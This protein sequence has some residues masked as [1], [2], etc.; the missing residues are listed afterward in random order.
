MKLTLGDWLGW[1]DE[2]HEDFAFSA[3]CRQE[4]PIIRGWN[5]WCGSCSSALVLLSLS[6]IDLDAE[7]KL[8]AAPHDE[9]PQTLF[10]PQT[11]ISPRGE[12]S[13]EQLHVTACRGTHAGH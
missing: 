8:K 13:P 12:N 9:V 7:L 2:R 3:P 6:A 11:V 4:L 1:L 5:H 10:F